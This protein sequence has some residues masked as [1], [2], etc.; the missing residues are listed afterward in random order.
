MSNSQNPTRLL[1]GV[2]EL[3][4]TP[5]EP[6]D[7]AGSMVRRVSEGV[8]DPL[9]VR[10]VVLANATTRLVFVLLD[11]IYLGDDACQPLRKRIASLLDI[12][13]ANVCISCTHTHRG[14]VIRKRNSYSTSRNEAWF[15][16]ML[17][18]VVESVTLASGTLV[19]AEAAWG[20]GREGRPQYNRRWH[21]EGGPVRTNPRPPEPPSHPAGPT[22]PDLPVLLIRTAEE[23]E[24]LAVIAN[25]SLHYIGDGPGRKISAD[26]F[27]AFADA[28][29]C[30]IGSPRTVAMLTHGASGDI[31]NLNAAGT[32]TP[33]YPENMVH[34]DRS[35]L[36]AGWLAAEVEALLGKVRWSR[37]VKLGAVEAS[38]LL[39]LREIREEDLPR[40]RREAE[41]ESLPYALRGYAR[42]RLNLAEEGGETQSKVIASLR[43]G[44]WAASTFPGEMFCQ[45]GI[46][47]K[48]ASPFPV[49][50]FLELT[51]GYSGYVATHYSY[52]L[53]GY[54]TW[55]GGSAFARPGSGEEMLRLA[56]TQ[57][58]ELYHGAPPVL[59]P[60]PEQLP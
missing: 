59:E 60:N 12:P 33:W 1:A 4:I 13:I 24:L 9:H 19:P 54:E 23:G 51:N 41:D 55:H 35:R 7:L 42:A 52:L 6:V 31:N 26:Y 44:D 37:E 3:D 29:K 20:R 2:A 50:A 45:F 36:I 58:H 15:A 49:T 5:S 10:T 28:I 53:G 8:Y 11:L 17:E 40:Y 30:R 47:L 56:I 22:D 18:R 14:P 21:L 25:Y 38:Y 46:D 27:G 16:W 39:R 48:F 57:L 34:G 43:V 32:P